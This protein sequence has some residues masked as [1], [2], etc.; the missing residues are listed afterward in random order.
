MCSQAVKM[1]PALL[2]LDIF[3]VNLHTMHRSPCVRLPQLLW[4]YQSV[5]TNV[6]LMRMPLDT[7]TDA[8]KLTKPPSQPTPTEAHTGHSPLA[9]PA[10][11]WLQRLWCLAEMQAALSRTSDHPAAGTTHAPLHTA[12]PPSHRIQLLNTLAR[13]LPALHAAAGY[14]V[15]VSPISCLSDTR[16]LVC[17]AHYYFSHTRHHLVSPHTPR[18][19]H[20]GGRTCATRRQAATT[21]PKCCASRWLREAASGDWTPR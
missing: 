10:L 19:V 17:C 9:S 2:Y 6:V 11:M 13:R 14:V 21:K 7:D 15:I 8:D 12:V 3:T 5:N 1:D 20:A 18:G 16:P 4:P